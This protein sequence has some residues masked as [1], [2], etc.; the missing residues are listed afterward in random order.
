MSSGLPAARSYRTASC[1]ILDL[2][3]F[4]PLESAG[5]DFHAALNGRRWAAGPFDQ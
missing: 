1:M 3:F 2:S 5:A 4:G